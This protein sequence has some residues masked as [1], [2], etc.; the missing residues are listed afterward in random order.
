MPTSNNT[1]RFASLSA[2]QVL[3]EQ[4]RLLTV[5]AAEDT[6]RRARNAAI[7]ASLDVR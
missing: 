2:A 3:T 7:L 4:S 5:R 6:V 1:G